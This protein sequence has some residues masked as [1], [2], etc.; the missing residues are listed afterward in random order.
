MKNFRYFKQFTILLLV[1]L[2]ISV[3]CQKESP[4]T[5]DYRDK[6]CGDWQ[7]T[8]HDVHNEWDSQSG[9]FITTEN[10]TFYPY[11]IIKKGDF[12]TTLLVSYNGSTFQSYTIDINGVFPNPPGTNPSF[13]E[14]GSVSDS[15]FYYSHGGISGSWGTS[16]SYTDGHR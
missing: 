1:I 8:H 7:F 11:G 10:I 14:G 13:P 4:P 6:F 9:Q 5:T 15:S 3:A 12:D 16:H 2:S